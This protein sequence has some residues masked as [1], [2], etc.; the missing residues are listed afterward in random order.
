MSRRI[1]GAVLAG[2][3][4]LRFGRDKTEE[5]FEGRKLI[6]RAI[7]L[8]RPHCGTLFVAGRSHHSCRGIADRPWPGI[9]P[10]GGIAGAMHVAAREG[11][12]H[13]LSLPCDTPR[14]PERLLE[15][16]CEA[17]DGAYVESCPVIGLWPTR[18]S[19]KLLYHLER[20]R[21]NAVRVWA[22]S[23]GIAVIEAGGPISNINRIADLLDI[24][25]GDG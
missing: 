16:L 3:R 4:S 14:L 23:A 7:D 20:G 12:T 25:A 15:T 24:A 9:G 2:G 6:D 13:L 17:A 10:L 19:E 11:Y 22:R 5:I 1:A 8:L 21:P 18:Y